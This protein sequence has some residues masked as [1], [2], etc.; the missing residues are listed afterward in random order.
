MTREDEFIQELERLEGV[1]PFLAAEIDWGCVVSLIA[2]LQLSL[3]HPGNV[4]VAATHAREFIDGIIIRI[5]PISPRLAALLP[6]ATTRNT[7]S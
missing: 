5:E 4:G 7:T 1:H 3:R 6:P 2:C